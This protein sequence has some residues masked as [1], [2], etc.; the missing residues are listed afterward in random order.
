MTNKKCGLL[1]HCYHII[2]IHEYS[3]HGEFGQRD[4][5][6]YMKKCCKCG[7]QRRDLNII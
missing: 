5:P 6:Y 7:K 4:N 3:N 1:Q 2:Q